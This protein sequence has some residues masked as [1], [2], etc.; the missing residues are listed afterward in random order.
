[1]NE[2]INLRQLK[3]KCKEDVFIQLIDDDHRLVKV[4]RFNSHDKLEKLE[5]LDYLLREKEYSKIRVHTTYE[6]E[7]GIVRARVLQG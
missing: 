6:D 5:Y 7:D 2:I 1:M 3:L 4:I